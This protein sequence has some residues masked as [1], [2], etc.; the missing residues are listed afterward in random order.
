M[1][2]LLR[3]ITAV[4]ALALAAGAVAGQESRAIA[5]AAH[6]ADLSASSKPA[7]SAS[8]LRA[9]TNAVA[10]LQSQIQELTSQMAELR[11]QEQQATSEA[12]DL[13][14][15]LDA[16]KAQL[17]ALNQPSNNA[18]VASAP[19]AAANAS[20]EN[21]NSDLKALADTVQ[22]GDSASKASAQD[23]LD[24]L[25]ENAQLT[26]GKIDDQ[27]QT[28]VESSSKYRVR[29]SGMALLNLY[30]NR[31][32]VD[33][34]DLPE[35]AVPG[36]PM[37][38]NSA[39]GGSI[40]Q[41]RIGLDVFGPDV[42]GAHT[43]ADVSFD[44]FGGFP[45]TENGQLTGVARLRTATMSLDWANTSIVAGQDY[46]FFAPIAPTSLAQFA[47][48]ALSY[49][50]NLWGWTPQ[51]RVEHRFALPGNSKLSISGGILAGLTGDIP[52]SQ[53][54][55]TP[56]WGEQS[57]QPAYAARVAWSAPFFG[58]R[59]LT[60][61]VGAY[62][63]RQFWGFG[64]YIDG[65]AGTTD[66]TL[67]LGSRFELTG[68]FYRGAAVGGFGG[69]VGQTIMLDGSLFTP[70]TDVDALPSEGG[71]VQLKYKATSKLEFNAAFGD[72]NPFAGALRGYTGNAGYY[73]YSITKNM[74]PFV[75]F[76][77]N[78]RSNVLFSL[79]YRYLRTYQLDLAPNTANHIN[80]A[81]G[82][83]F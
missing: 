13:R 52:Q 35:V 33:N 34:Q 4:A 53:E 48:P 29:I 58:D 66:L 42:F 75:N 14:K 55:R 1:K 24:T 81:I 10:A 6:P 56:S 36:N 12:E 76:I 27:Y 28:K 78:V 31:G 39:F 68:E 54:D 7:D 38:S 69:A 15:E 26:E 43:H 49:A 77:Y 83:V 47:T 40:R 70:S 74:S 82:Y 71:W 44:F 73:G 59:P 25:E 67:P 23:R 64:R 30:D 46:L 41:S 72:D 50:G 51:I 32:I 80:M 61:G 37:A 3:G 63:D 79:E 62:F 11:Q 5:A 60:F 2:F 57:G 22:P 17:A 16:T 20:A 21:S 19:Q 8:D 45:D 18:T 65:W 9:L